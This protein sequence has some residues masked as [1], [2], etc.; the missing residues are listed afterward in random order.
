MVSTSSYVDLIKN[1][2]KLEHTPDP[3]RG[4]HPLHT[5]LKD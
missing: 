3:G 4:F 5:R 2:K 1:V